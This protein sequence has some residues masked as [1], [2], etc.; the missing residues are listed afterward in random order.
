MAT[1]LR[2]IYM[3]LSFMRNR[4]ATQGSTSLLSVTVLQLRAK[5]V[6]NILKVIKQ[7]WQMG[8][9]KDYITDLLTCIEWGI[10][11]GDPPKI[12]VISIVNYRHE[13][14]ELKLNTT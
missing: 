6:N 8:C 7:A 4:L 9:I 11:Y 12:V 14:S 5:A 13:C 2:G 10:M 3:I 1:L